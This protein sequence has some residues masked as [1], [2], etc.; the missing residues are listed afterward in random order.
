MAD[1]FLLHTQVNNVVFRYKRT[2]HQSVEKAAY[3]RRIG[4]LLHIEQADCNAAYTL[5]ARYFLWARSFPGSGQRAWASCMSMPG[6]VIKQQIARD[7]MA[8]QHVNDNWMQTDQVHDIL[9]CKEKQNINKRFSLGTDCI[10]K[11]SPQVQSPSTCSGLKGRPMTTYWTRHLQVY[12]WY[13][14]W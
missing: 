13:G 14:I 11:P 1:V 7:G 4:I 5:S 8:E 3:E 10:S 12:F 6:H 2:G 9:F